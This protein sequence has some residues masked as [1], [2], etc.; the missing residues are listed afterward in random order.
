MLTNKEHLKVLEEIVRLE[1]TVKTLEENE[2]LRLEIR[3]LKR[4][5]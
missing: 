2:K 3:K 4:L 5:P 1:E